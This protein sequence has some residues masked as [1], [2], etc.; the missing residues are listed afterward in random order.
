M[1]SPDV[2][3]GADCAQF[4]EKYAIA[5]IDPSFEKKSSEEYYNVSLTGPMPKSEMIGRV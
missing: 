5:I 3:E 2:L 4:P 1:N